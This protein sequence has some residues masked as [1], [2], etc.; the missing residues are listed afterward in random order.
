[1]IQVMRKESKNTV[2]TIIQAL[3][4]VF[5]EVVAAENKLFR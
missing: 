4:A 2:N 3:S 1:M 5:P